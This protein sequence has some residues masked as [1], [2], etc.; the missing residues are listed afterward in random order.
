[1]HNYFIGKGNLSPFLILDYLQYCVII[2]LHLF[3]SVF[4][5]LS[6]VIYT[7]DPILPTCASC[8]SIHA[9]SNPFSCNIVD[10]VC[11]N[12]WPVA[13]PLYPI[14]LPE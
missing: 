11:R 4:K 1:M 2:F 13:R 9:L 8:N 14:K 10:M 3:F 12:P 5:I 7:S 6:M